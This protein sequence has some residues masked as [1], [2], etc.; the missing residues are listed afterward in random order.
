MLTGISKSQGRP[1]HVIQD[2]QIL[3]EKELPPE[4]FSLVQQT[5]GTF[6]ILCSEVKIATK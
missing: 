3:Q 1:E 6:V 2:V 5:T 4:G